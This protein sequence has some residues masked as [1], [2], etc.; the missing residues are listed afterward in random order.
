MRGSHHHHHHTDPALRPFTERLGGGGFSARIF[1]GLNVGDKP[2]YTIEDV[3]KDT[4]A[5]RKRQ[6]ILPDASFVAQRGVYTEQRSGQLVTENSV[7]IIII[8]L[9]G[10]S[11]EDFTGK[12]QALGKELRE[13]FKQ[14]SV[15]VEI[16]ER[17]IVQ[18]VYSITAEWYEEGPMRPL[19]VDLQ[20]S[21][22]S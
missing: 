3:V 20:P 16:Q 13:D 9:E 8:D 1:V 6:G 12:V 4:I 15:I 22:I 14:E 17:G 11:K 7:Q 2:T 18:D 5:I 21:L 10:L 19:R